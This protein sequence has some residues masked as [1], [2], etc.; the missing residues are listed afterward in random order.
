MGKFYK[1]TPEYGVIGNLQ[2]QYSFVE[3]TKLLLKEMFGSEVKN[4][5][6]A[7]ENPFYIYD[8]DAKDVE[9]VIDSKKITLTPKEQGAVAVYRYCTKR[10]IEPVIRQIE[11]NATEIFSSDFYNL[12]FIKIDWKWGDIYR[13]LQNARAVCA[14]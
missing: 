4:M 11:K 8:K 13:E 3:T 2:Q 5:V 1:K 6:V 12:F 9:L 14:D 10:K 7:S